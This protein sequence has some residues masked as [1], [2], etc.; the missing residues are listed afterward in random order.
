MVVERLQI[1]A[2]CFTGHAGKGLRGAAAINAAASVRLIKVRMRS[3]S[4]INR[5]TEVP[6]ELV[7]MLPGR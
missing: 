4:C 3:P 2:V 6:E 5:A 7:M 1:A